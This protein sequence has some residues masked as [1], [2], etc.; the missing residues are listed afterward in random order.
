MSV[1]CYPRGCLCCASVRIVC[2]LVPHRL[3]VFWFS[4]VCL[5]SVFLRVVCSLLR[6]LQSVE[7]ELHLHNFVFIEIYLTR[8]LPRCNPLRTPPG[9]E[10]LFLTVS[11]DVTPF[12]GRDGVYEL[13][14]DLESTR[15]LR[16][17]NR[18]FQ[19]TRERQPRDQREG[20]RSILFL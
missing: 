19:L 6:P 7:A 15:Y 8:C 10:T 11:E 3:S 5:F 2:F 20:L 13:L 17:I 18:L 12:L 1:F 9:F 4:M 14:Y 16:P